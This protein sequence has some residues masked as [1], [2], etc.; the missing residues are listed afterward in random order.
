MSQTALD[1]PTAAS[2]L[3]A[4]WRDYYEMCKPKVVL[5]MLLCAAVGAF[6]ATPALPALGTLVA[7]LTLLRI[8]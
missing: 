7:A 4:S 5:L 2:E 3:A 8:G 6:L 1:N